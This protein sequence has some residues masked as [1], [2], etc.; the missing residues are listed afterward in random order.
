MPCENFTQHYRIAKC[1]LL[2]TWSFRMLRNSDSHLFIHIRLNMIHHWDS[3]LFWI[4]AISCG[5]RTFI[6]STARI[7]SMIYCVGI[8]DFVIIHCR[9]WSPAADTYYIYRHIYAFLCSQIVSH[10]SHN[11]AA[12]SNKSTDNKSISIGNR[13]EPQTEMFSMSMYDVYSG[14]KKKKKKERN[15]YEWAMRSRSTWI[16]HSDS[17]ITIERDFIFTSQNWYC[18]YYLSSHSFL[19][20][21]RIEFRFIKRWM[22]CRF[23]S[24]N[25]LPSAV[26]VRDA[27]RPRCWQGHWFNLLD[28]EFFVSINRRTI[29][30][31]SIYISFAIRHFSFLFLSFCIVFDPF[32]QFLGLS[33]ILS[34]ITTE[35]DIK[36][37]L[38]RS[39]T[40]WNEV[41]RSAWWGRLRGSSKKRKM[42]SNWFSLNEIIILPWNLF[43]FY[44]VHVN[45][46]ICAAHSELNEQLIFDNFVDIVFGNNHIHLFVAKI[47]FFV[48][49][50]HFYTN[51]F[52]IFQSPERFTS[53]CDIING[54]WRHQLPRLAD[55]ILSFIDCVIL[56]IA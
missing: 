55:K 2:R 25:L 39:H 45:S 12:H 36:K 38:V 4:I 16:L 6:A 29:F 44:F 43:H 32:C 18:L 23:L 54:E 27:H 3:S 37:H 20:F 30:P 56:W 8:A 1:T 22:K 33:V 14:K 24:S 7:R 41:N 11:N 5:A 31:R 19:L 35:N 52:I 51:S 42:I 34:D 40:K 21:V 46:S 9:A 53:R 49:Y 10:P 48:R 17:C 26:Y 13:H 47:F 28:R 50:N 15:R